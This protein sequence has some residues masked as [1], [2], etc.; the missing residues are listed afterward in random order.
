MLNDSSL[1]MR[2]DAVEHDHEKGRG[3]SV[4]TK[5]SAATLYEKALSAARDTDQID[6]AFEKLE[7]LGRKIDLPTH[8]G[9]ITSVAS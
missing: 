4:T 7:E 5:K 3:R 1:E 9:F 2:R 6:A 8:F